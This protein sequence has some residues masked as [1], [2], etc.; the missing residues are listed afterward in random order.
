[1]DLTGRLL[2]EWYSLAHTRSSDYRHDTL[3]AQCERIRR[4]I[5]RERLQTNQNLNQLFQV[6]SHETNK[7]ARMMDNFGVRVS[8]Q[9]NLRSEKFEGP[10]K[11]VLIFELQPVKSRVVF[12]WN[13]WRELFHFGKFVVLMGQPMR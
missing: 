9:A 5:T 3:S 6:G 1:M 12:Y 2:N 11:V 13:F 7:L 4:M 8:L 10:P